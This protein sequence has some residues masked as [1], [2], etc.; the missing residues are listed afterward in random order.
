MAPDDY[1]GMKKIAAMTSIPL[2]AGENEYTKYGFRV[3]I[4]THAVA[5]HN[6]APFLNGGITETMKIAALS[7]A[8]DLE[9]APHGDQTINVTI[10]AAIPNVSYVEYYPKEY[11]ALWNESL[12]YRLTIDND[13]TMSPTERPGIGFEPNYE[14]LN[15]HRVK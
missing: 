11:D 3:L 12:D 7:Q 8:F 13:G 15:P 10:G 2:A 1:D 14:A 4:L 6:P 5:I 9:L